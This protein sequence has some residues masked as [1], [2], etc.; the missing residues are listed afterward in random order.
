MKTELI[1]VSPTRKEIKI[2]IPPAAVKEV[3]DKVSKKYAKAAQ[4]D[5]FRKGFAP[6]DVV[7]MRYK[8]DIKSDVLQELLPNKVTE[9]IQEHELSPLAEP[10]L[11]LEDQENLK[12]NGS[13]P[14]NLS[15]HVEVM[16]EIPEPDYKNLEVTKR[17]RPIEDG[18]LDELIDHRRQEYATLLPVED[19][20]SEEGDTVIANLEGKIEGDED[21][22]PIKV[23]DLEVKLGDEL[24][25]QS[26]TDNLM[27][28]EQDE[29]KEFTVSYPDDFTSPVLAG[30]TVHYK[31][32][33]TS[34]G[35]VELP[36]LDDEWAKS[37]D[38]GYESMSDLREKL[39]A[40]LQTISE[41]EADNRL[42][43]DLIAKIIENHPFEVPNALIDVQARNLLNNFGQDLAQR[44]VD[45]EKV[46]KDFIEMAYMQMRDQAERDVRGAMLLEK[47][48]EKEKAEVSGDE[49]AEEIERIADYYQT[50]AEEVRASLTQQGGEEGIAN[51]LRTRKAVEAL[52]E[53]AKITDGEWVDETQ[54]IAEAEQREKEEAEKAKSDSEK[55]NKS[56]AEKKTKKAA[57][58]SKE[59]KPKAEK[60]ETKNKDEKK[61]S[62]E[63]SEKKSDKKEKKTKDKK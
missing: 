33:I 12:L 24:I 17:V 16:P 55:E 7:R 60:K 56:K 40:D 45:L 3:Y 58:E 54:S 53:N 61:E 21:G 6:V 27:G 46:E 41:A 51:S 57:G 31:A 1:E 35:R 25:E 38:E 43:S 22:Q 28:V 39:R 36:E 18:E 23:D 2:E 32:K 52:R 50:T 8:D 19:R 11:H 29:E 10:H 9:A 59:K 49:I 13:Q 44:G 47:I 42:R 63:K 20:K 48:A 26:F 5:G 14:I 37:L 4:V 15:V 30:K 34:V 62:K